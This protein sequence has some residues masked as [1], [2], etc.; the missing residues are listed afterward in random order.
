MID[1]NGTSALMPFRPSPAANMTHA[2][3]VNGTLTL[4]V[5]LLLVHQNPVGF[6]PKGEGIG[7]ADQ[8]LVMADLIQVFDLCMVHMC[9]SMSACLVL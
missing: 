1:V 2:T 8:L 5:L 3:S 7:T 9:L 6:V 4:L